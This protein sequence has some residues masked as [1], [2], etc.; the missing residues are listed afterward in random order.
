MVASRP[1]TAGSNQSKTI[2]P[3]RPPWRRSAP[4]PRKTGPTLAARAEAMGVVVVKVAGMPLL[5]KTSANPDVLRPH[6]V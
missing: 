6:T 2:V 1:L 5:P 3:A 4:R